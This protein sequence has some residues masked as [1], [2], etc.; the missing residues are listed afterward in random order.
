MAYN[1]YIAIMHYGNVEQMFKIKFID[2]GREPKCAPDPA[3]PHGMVADLAQGA[4]R[5][6]ETVIPYPSP[7]CGLVA[8]ECEKCGL[9]VVVTVAGRPDDVHTVR[10]ACKETLQ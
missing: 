4:S 5:V 3:F 9:K 1:I 10:M 7:R 2:S 8:I 6:C